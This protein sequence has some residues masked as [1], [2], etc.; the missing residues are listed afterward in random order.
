[1]ID[2]PGGEKREDHGRVEAPFWAR[3]LRYL[4]GGIFRSGGPHTDGGAIAERRCHFCRVAS[5]SSPPD[6]ISRAGKTNVGEEI[7]RMGEVGSS[8]TVLPSGGID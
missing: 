3:R 5:V 7:E 4:A 2:R 8:A 1:M 6:S